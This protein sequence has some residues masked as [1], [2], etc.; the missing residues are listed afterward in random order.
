MKNKDYTKG[1]IKTLCKKGYS[2]NAI[3][4][5]FGFDKSVVKKVLKGKRCK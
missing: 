1:D 3:I 5:N 4:K 2:R